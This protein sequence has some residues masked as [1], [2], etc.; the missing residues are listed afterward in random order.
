MHGEVAQATRDVAF[1]ERRGAHHRAPGL[2]RDPHPRAPTPSRHAVRPP[3]ALQR[4][5]QGE[6]GQLVY[7]MKRP[8]GGSLFLLL[9]PDEFLARLATLAPPDFSELGPSHD[10]A[11]PVYAD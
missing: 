11:D 8:R 4:R 10:G 7:R 1:R 2:V 9:E 5:S 6:N 3:F